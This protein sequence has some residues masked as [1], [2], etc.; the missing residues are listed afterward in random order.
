MRRSLARAIKSD[1]APLPGAQPSPVGR[2]TTPVGTAVRSIIV[3]GSR[4]SGAVRASEIDDGDV[5]VLREGSPEQRLYSA[6]SD[7]DARTTRGPGD[8]ID[9]AVQALV[10]GLDS[11]AL[12]ELAGAS[13]H[14]ATPDIRDLV[15]KVIV[16]LRLP[17]PGAGVVRGSGIDSL[18]LAIASVGDVFEVQVYVNGVEM[19]KAGAGL[20]M[21]PYDVLVP[22]NRLVATEQRR[23]VPIARCVC[24][25]YGCGS[26]DVTIVRDGDLVHWD[27]LL[28]VPM[29]RGVTFAAGQYDAEV[30]RIAADH[31]WETS[32]R[33]AGRLILTNVNRDRLA[34]YGLAPDWVANDHRNPQ[35]FR[36]CLRMGHDYQIFVDTPWDD[37]TPPELARDVLAMLALPPQQWRASWH[38]MN[39]AADGPPTIAGRAWS[40]ARF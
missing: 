34:T 32:Q 39:P 36:V 26:T 20:G 37:R 24:G 14:D 8:L 31:S 17:Q 40:E 25:N 10:D 1:R 4:K 28:D 29:D 35:Q 7:W 16:E 15:S 33:T 18:R 5:P 12:R 27:W 19:T 2:A 3:K 21:D 30:A 11:P 38:A 6:V 23:T 22:A 13:V 9:A